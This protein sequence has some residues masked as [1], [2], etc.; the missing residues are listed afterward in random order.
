MPPITKNPICALSHCAVFSVIWMSTPKSDV[1]QIWSVFS[2][3][4]LCVSPL[5]K[6]CLAGGR[7]VLSVWHLVAA[8]VHLMHCNY[9][10]VKRPLGQHVHRGYC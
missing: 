6:H 5:C 2:S 4:F 1:F 9:F 7:L 10:S 3:L 8:V